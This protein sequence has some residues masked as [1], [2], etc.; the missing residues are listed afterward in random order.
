MFVYLLRKKPNIVYFKIHSGHFTKQM[1]SVCIVANN[2]IELE[3]FTDRMN[4]SNFSG[5]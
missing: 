1:F 4:R 5:E 2:L 3:A